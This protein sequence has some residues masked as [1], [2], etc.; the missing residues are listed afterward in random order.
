VGQT[1]Y[2]GF[3]GSAS[4][5]NFENIFEWTD[6]VTLIRGNHAIKFGS[7]LRRQ[8]FDQL[9]G[10][11]GTN[12]FGPIF[13]SNSNAPGSG[14]PWADFL[15][16]YISNQQVGFRELDWGRLRFLYSGTYVQDDWRITRRLTLNIGLR[17]ELFTQPV[18]ARNLGGLYNI[19]TQQF[20][21]PGKGGYTR[22][23]VDGDHN[24]FAPRVGL[25][26]QG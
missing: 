26:Y 19:Y 25:A 10:G 21:Q 2:T 22:A 16:G 6:N 4:N 18:D 23:I 3:G 5:L 8:R 1:I 14:D 20:V 7:D 11:F 24:N 12:Y 13:S 9:S 17:Y 15:M